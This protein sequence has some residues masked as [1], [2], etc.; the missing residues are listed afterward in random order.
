MAKSV[1][2]VPPKGIKSSVPPQDPLDQLRDRIV[3]HL[4]KD[5]WDRAM[6]PRKR[7]FQAALKDRSR[8]V[9]EDWVPGK[10]IRGVYLG[11]FVHR[12]DKYRA[13][14]A[15]GGTVQIF[16]EPSPGNR[17]QELTAPLDRVAVGTFVEIDCVDASRFTVRARPKPMK[18]FQ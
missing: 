2:T 1:Q 9:V 10:R 15:K 3:A 17:M 11:V 16:R 8:H 13:I 12:S 4:S 6:F 18:E 7:T 5:A 14:I